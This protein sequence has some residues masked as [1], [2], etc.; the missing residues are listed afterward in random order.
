[1]ITLINPNASVEVVKRLDISTPPLG[2]GYLAASLREAGFRVKILDDL[3]ENLSLNEVLRRVRKSLI[4]G[5]TSTTPTFKAALRYAK[6]IK[7]A[8]PNIFI[9]L[10]GVHATF[11]PMEALKTGY[12]DAV[13]IGEGEETIVEIAECI[14]E[15]KDLE[16][17]R[18]VYYRKG[19][20]ITENEPREFIKDLDSLPYPAYDLM[21]LHKY[22]VFGREL[23]HLPVLTSRG[24][25]FGCRFCSSSLFMGH[26]FRARS[27]ENV[28][29]EVE[30]ISDEFGIRRIAFADD[31]FTLNRKRVEEICE[32]LKKLDVEW[33]CS[34]RVDT[35]NE[36]LLKKMKKAGCTTIYFGVEAAS[37]K[38][39]DYYR[40]RIDLQK[41]E[42]AIKLAKK[43]GIVTVCS[44]ILGA[45]NETKEEMEET[46]RLALKLDP[47]Y[48]Q[49]SI[50]TPY[51]GTEIY[52]ELRDKGLILTD[53]YE[54]YTAGKPVIKN[55]YLSPSEISSF[56]RKCYLKFYFRP[57]FI[58]REI[59]RKNISVVAGVIKRV[60]GG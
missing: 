43:V 46:L 60:I 50:L 49:F 34:S 33:S 11:R 4:V 14:E 5:I 52:D 2:L 57:K 58:L 6:L 54:H 40:K 1:M 31:T 21:P 55:F 38:V 27:A 35:I 53:D 13:C 39:L 23:E 42:R 18:G 19:D 15:G 10:G 56:L 24:C 16:S 7:Q 20:R 3:V 30:W 48:A 47:D 29:E 25:P 26:R 41:V 22:R 17:V 36:E 8:F 37:K 28:A 59:R 12:V 44:F 45:P 51:P 9:I 32:R